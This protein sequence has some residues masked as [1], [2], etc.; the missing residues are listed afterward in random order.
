MKAGANK[1]RSM[2][3]GGA[4]ELERKLP[5][6]AAR[7]GVK[8][9]AAETSGSPAVAKLAK[10]TPKEEAERQGALKASQDRATGISGR[11]TVLAEDEV[12]QKTKPIFSDAEQA[13]SKQ[14]REGLTD[15]EKAANAQIQAQLDS[16]ITPTTLTNSESG[17][18]LREKFNAFEENVRK[19]AQ[20]NYPIFHQKAAEE[21]IVLKKDAVTNLRKAIEAEDP[22]GAAELL[23]PS[24][25]QVKN[26]EESLT[27]PLA[28]ATPPKRVGFSVEPGKPEVPAPDLSF[29]DAIRLRPL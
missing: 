8:T 26:V 18:Y 25:K 20:K 21:G 29:E 4:G 12:A 17:K 6:A 5:E 14:V 3:L 19:E 11:N 9:T 10:L 28:A 27:K 1:V 22:T 16:G 15:A 23:A 24:I 7:L 13:A 2:V